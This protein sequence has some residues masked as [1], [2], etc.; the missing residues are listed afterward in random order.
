MAM[1]LD[2]LVIALVLSAAFL[3]AAWNALVKVSADQVTMTAMMN[4]AGM[5]LGLALVL[6]AAAP[7]RESWPFIV[8]SA[9]IHLGYYTFLLLAYR[10]GDLSQV[11]P[12][13]RGTGPLI[14]ALLSGPLIGERLAPSQLM[15][16]LLLSLG[17][18]S[19]AF[20]NLRLTW[21]L[22]ARPILCALATGCFIAAYT[23]ND[24]MG[25][26]RSASAFGYIGWLFVLDGFSMLVIALVLRGRRFAAAVRSTW[27][28]GF[29]GGIMAT[30]GYGA[31]IW[32]YNL[33]AIAPIA[34]LRE[35]SVVA[36]AAIGAVILREPFG[37]WRILAAC[38]VAIGIVAINLPSH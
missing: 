10:G 25:V 18:I 30:A 8:A 22:D 31:V 2:P 35:T 5:A 37:R 29:L 38:C 28:L 3:H 13:S 14:V 27:K 24:G 36:A 34:A 23:V 1:G 33:G 19:I 6:A 12:L 21:R 32:C 4:L 11:Y 7:A 17:I 26:R 9:L 20:H 15:G 16:V